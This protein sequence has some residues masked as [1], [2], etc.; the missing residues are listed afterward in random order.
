[1]TYQVVKCY[2][3]IGLEDI[4]AG[5]TLFKPTWLLAA[6][7]LLISRGMTFATCL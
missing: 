3:G 6:V 2:I 1:M 5:Y 7:Q 4:E